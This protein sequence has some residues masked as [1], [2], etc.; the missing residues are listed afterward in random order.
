MDRETGINVGVRLKGTRVQRDG[1]RGTGWWV[2]NSGPGVLQFLGC[3]SNNP[4]F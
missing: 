4:R 2:G 1:V 3:C